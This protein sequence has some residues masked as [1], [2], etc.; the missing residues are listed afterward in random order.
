MIDLERANDSL[1][2]QCK[3]NDVMMAKFAEEIRQMDVEVD[4]K[5]KEQ[6][7]ANCEN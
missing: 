4:R 7:M 5:R 3:D 1:R 6:D 2:E